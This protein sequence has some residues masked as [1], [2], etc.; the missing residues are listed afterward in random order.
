[1]SKTA[2][3]YS[4]LYN[5]YKKMAT[6]KTPFQISN[7][8]LT[9]TMGEMLEE[10]LSY[11]AL[12]Q[13][14]GDLDG[15]G[16]PTKAAFYLDPPF[17]EE[18]GY[19]KD[20]D[21]MLV[22]APVYKHMYCGKDVQWSWCLSDGDTLTYKVKDVNIGEG[23]IEMNGQSF[24]TFEDYFNIRIKSSNPSTES[25]KSI[26][27]SSSTEENDKK[28][29]IRFVGINCAET[30]HFE[31]KYMK[32][33]SLEKTISR[34]KFKDIKNNK[35]YK[36]WRYPTDNKF[37][38]DYNYQERKDDEILYFV[39][40][41]TSEGTGYHEI[42]RHKDASE[43]YMP[44]PNGDMSHE[45][46]PYE[47]VLSKFKLDAPEIDGWDA[48][49]NVALLILGKDET[50]KKNM[51][52]AYRAQLALKEQLEASNYKTRLVLDCKT[53]S[54]ASTF[55]SAG[56]AVFS[57]FYTSEF[58]KTVWDQMHKE[59]SDL[60][61]SGY[62]YGAY[63]ADVYGRYLG[64]IYSK[65][66]DGKWINLNKYVL[67]N[68]RY[69][70]PM[71]D[72]SGHPEL[73]NK[74]LS[75]A[76]QLWSY[77]INR[78]RWLD[79][80]EELTEE[81]YNHRIELHEKL[82]GLKFCDIRD[83]SLLIGDTLMLIPPT[84]IRSV[85]QTTYEK[86]PL[87]R[88]KGQITK[89]GNHNESIL[90]L[91]LYF[92]GDHGING[93][94]Y[95]M[96]LP[97]GEEVTYYMNGLRSLVSQFKLTP[98]L[99]IEN[100][101]INDVLNI[102]AVSL[103]NLHVTTVPDYPH[104]LQAV[105][106]LREFNYRLFMP[107][108]PLGIEA[109]ESLS[110]NALAETNP[111]FAKAFQWEVFRYY[112]QR[113]LLAGETI[114]K[115]D[116]NS[117]EY[118]TYLYRG[119]TALKP[120][121]LCNSNVSFYIPDIDWL[122]KVLVRIKDRDKAIIEKESIELTQNTRDF[123][124]SISDRIEEITPAA[125]NAKKAFEEHIVGSE[126]FDS[127]KVEK[128]STNHN[129]LPGYLNG[130]TRIY[131]KG[132][133]N[134]IITFYKPIHD[135]V[136]RQ[137]LKTGLFS[138]VQGE[139][140]VTSKKNEST[141]EKEWQTV[142]WSIKAKLGDL[143]KK[144]T[145]TE[146]S[147][148]KESIA[149]NLST[150]KEAILEDDSLVINI[151]FT[152]DKEGNVLEVSYDS[153]L[154]TETLENLRRIGNNELTQSDQNAIDD[155]EYNYRDP[156]KMPFVP[157]IEDII[158]DEMSIS[159]S[160]LFTETKLK[161]V[162]GISG[163][164]VGGQDSTINLKITTCDKLVVATLATLKDISFQF[165]NEY[166]RIMACTPIRIKSDF[167]QMYGINE[168]A[169]EMIDINTI[170]NMPGAYE[171]T[172]RLS[173]VDRTTRQRENLRKMDFNSNG[174]FV[175]T[176]AAGKQSIKSYFEIEDVL[177]QVELYPDLEIPTLEE[178]KLRGYAYIKYAL[179]NG[180]RVYPDPDF[181]M[182][183]ANSY[184]AAIMK[185]QIKDY[186]DNLLSEDADTEE[187]E[188]I[189]I[190]DTETSEKF[191]SKLDEVMGLSLIGQN[192]AADITDKQMNAIE[193][194]LKKTE[195][196]NNK[197]SNKSQKDAKDA[198]KALKFLMASKVTSGWQLKPTWT[199]P[200]CDPS[201]NELISQMPK[202]GT[203][204]SSDLSD[205]S[206]A[207][208]LKTTRRDIIKI[209]DKIL[210]EPINMKSVEVDIKTYNKES[211]EE[212]IIN[213][214]RSVV[215]DFFFNDTNGKALYELLNPLKGK[216]MV[217]GDTYESAE[218]TEWV[219][220]F[221]YAAACV[222]SS[223]KDFNKKFMQIDKINGEWGPRM[224]FNE[225]TATHNWNSDYKNIYVPLC[226]VGDSNVGIPDIEGATNKELE[227]HMLDDAINRG[228]VFGPF[229]IR[230]YT[231][232]ELVNMST[233]EL[234]I[235]YVSAEEYPLYKHTI[236]DGFLDPYY[237]K[238]N[239]DSEELTK[240][241]KG[242]MLN[243]KVAAQAFLRNCLV[244]MRKLILDGLFISDVDI[245]AVDLL[246]LFTNNKS[247][248]ENGKLPNIDTE[249][250]DEKKQIKKVIQAMTDNL[251][252]SMFIN[253]DEREI[254]DLYLIYASMCDL[255]PKSFCARMIYPIFL[256]ATDGSPLIYND[257][258]VRNYNSL[259]AAVNMSL[260]G[261]VDDILS[262]QVCTFFNAMAGQGMIDIQDTEKSWTD[263]SQKITNSV[264]KEVYL[265]FANNP[266]IYAMHSYYDMLMND[267]RG[268]LIRAFPTYYMILIDEGR[269]I[270]YWKLHDNFYNMS[271]ISDIQVVKSRKM[272]ADTA[273][274]TMTNAYNSYATEHDNYTKYKYADLYGV[275]DVF[276]SIF[277]PKR[278]YE[279]AEDIRNNTPVKDKVVLKPGIRMHIRMGY[280]AD[281]SRIPVIFNGRITEVNTG[282]VVDIVAQGDG[283]ELTN[284]LNTLGDIE[285]NQIDTAQSLFF[286]SVLTDF[287]GSF[288]KGGLSPK[289]LLASI[290]C[291][292][293]GGIEGIVNHVFNGKYFNTN[294]FG[295]T[296]FGDMRF[297]E[298]FSQ[299][300][301]AQNL[302]E[303]S[304]DDLLRDINSI[305]KG[306]S[307]K[308]DTPIINT[309]LYDK[310]FWDLMHMSARAGK[311]Y[312]AAVR[313]FGFRS[314]IFLGQNNHYY[315]Y[316]YKEVNGDV[317]EKR[318]PF[319]QYHYIEPYNDIIYNTIK[320]SE[321]DIKT[322]ATGIWQATNLTFGR[323]SSTV[324][325]F[326][327]D[328]NIYPEYQKSMTYDTGLLA[329][330]AGGI[331][332]NPIVKF[333]E[334]ILSGKMGQSDKTYDNKVNVKLAERMTI[335]ALKETVKDMY[336]GE[337]CI[338][339]SPAIK[340]FD[341]VHIFD[342]QEDMFGDFE[343]ETVIHSLNAYTGFTTTIHPDLIVRH[344]ENKQE[345]AARKIGDS[346]S[347]TLTATAM[348]QLYKHAFART[349][350]TLIKNVMKSSVVS[351]T[352]SA[353]MKTVTKTSLFTK[354][355]DK[356]DSKVTKAIVDALD[357]VLEDAGNHFN[358]VFMKSIQGLTDSLLD[359]G[360]N[361]ASSTKDLIK[362][363]KKLE[364]LN[365]EKFKENFDSM[366]ESAKNNG[367][368]DLVDELSDDMKEVIK[369]Y[370]NM[371]NDL[372]MSDFFKAVSNDKDL[373]K[374]INKIDKDLFEYFSKNGY[375]ITSREDLKKFNK[376]FQSDKVLETIA[377]EGESVIGSAFKKGMKGIINFSSE[378]AE[379]GGLKAMQGIFKKGT[380]V[381]SNLALK[382]KTSPALTN[383]VSAV[384]QLLITETIGLYS[385][386][387]F[388]TWFDSLQT[389]TIYPMKQYGKNFTA[390]INGAKACTYASPT[391]DGWNSVQG[392]VIQAYET[393][394]RMNPV[395][396][397]FAQGFLDSFIANPDTFKTIA[398][399]YKANLGLIEDDS[400]SE[401]DI[402]TNLYKTVSTNMDNYGTSKHAI[403]TRAR[404]QSFDRKNEKVS[405]S[406]NEYAI[407][408][409]KLDQ[410]ATNTKISELI[411]LDYFPGIQSYITHGKLKIGHNHSNDS[412]KTKIVVNGKNVDINMLPTK[413]AEEKM[414][415]N[416]PD[417]PMLQEDAAVI[418]KTI[419]D[420]TYLMDELA[421]NN[422]V[423]HSGTVAN[424]ND[425]R[426]TGFHFILEASNA[427]VT[428]AFDKAK[429]TLSTKYKVFEYTK[430]NGNFYTFKVYPPIY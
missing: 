102:E 260:S 390:G 300:E 76:F 401:D 123:A 30:P 377:A 385:R 278:Y 308:C 367:V 104:M 151:H 34:V 204:T 44:I 110:Q 344:K 83:N 146:I 15:S 332:V 219:K 165:A 191:I 152:A 391:A 62:A 171:V 193:E 58:I 420:E 371:M 107:D 372:D 212:K 144:L 353:L 93:I 269:K 194:A 70:I 363:M 321:S 361:E 275:K 177:S 59:L 213:S 331:E 135:T 103:L 365:M 246:K 327:L 155:E 81:S 314:T 156:V 284:P 291:A 5:K 425:W 297:T 195:E 63:G 383:I 335:N 381:L 310:T 208:K 426:S 343:V 237:N 199:A 273:S 75:D 24:K 84:N 409:I 261:N 28:F 54:M 50:E 201:T 242:I 402:V 203:D 330:G 158:T 47:T 414:D 138:K 287:R 79:S 82:S 214:I 52:D 14:S 142:I 53:L 26:T 189:E 272:A 170:E 188:K 132:V 39:Q 173:S 130:K 250:D 72:Y 77:D 264:S 161:G 410:L 375:K 231:V 429:K 282:E 23:P 143:S 106:T 228:H 55:T 209:I 270:G 111:I 69:T 202:A 320:A 288:A 12:L 251:F 6:T 397:F 9:P 174:G 154:F 140:R 240:Y 306:A 139:E 116:Y 305:S 235:K 42:I 180:K 27:R 416:T 150:E 245:L 379:K 286:P 35:A 97:S 198:E 411:A 396:K 362:C 119:I 252:E 303:V 352:S 29:M 64:A 108:L 32:K 211:Q 20:L 164:Y 74:E 227:K 56:T 413:K 349:N 46:K 3:Q 41:T 283:I 221:L 175:G 316:G 268:R 96:T 281:A 238:L 4:Q 226:N 11:E 347:G 60:N 163:Q 215:N 324:G 266:K 342:S 99:P 289:N 323:K 153:S 257:M 258:K 122:D 36:Y 101:Y 380:N 359:I 274:V 418:L 210:S 348:L 404:I 95:K 179:S 412:K 232:D 217:S 85:T 325:P 350:S 378:A 2:E 279:K 298:I 89:G 419:L 233:P 19:D 187:L 16:N 148:L 115:Y 40:M 276:D 370:D 216:Y 147:H 333:A 49:K 364:D 296:H 355:L 223:E 386:S 128:S 131:A 45:G 346:I 68:S 421:N 105:L 190:Y 80:F 277:S 168:V 329:D 121:S 244:W 399:T 38:F 301:T 388:Q 133:I 160:N 387:I 167:T 92:A 360:I 292:E 337:V 134:P 43:N 334:G 65:T 100:E 124:K 358:S 423:F 317:F 249:K 318:K 340:P 315:A 162:D 236:K 328:I 354:N 37:D 192:K 376:I 197:N 427:N 48:D 307:K 428:K 120:T 304:D 290:L 220:G 7:N 406:F 112:Y 356:F 126:F 319:Q 339:G 125:E 338:L 118:N 243:S 267:K 71:P 294:P 31:V 21:A 430:S 345:I 382:V 157:L 136:E 86:T 369:S 393:V 109:Q 22:E 285:A 247:I 184:T 149:L 224:W 398:N 417:L 255:L 207:Y 145:D 230:T 206:A 33:D 218:L 182:V 366:I 357:N 25:N 405:T 61:I 239:E 178:L 185:A 13:T 400:M 8:I 1:M 351:S 326:Y 66:K 18:L 341:R 254:S 407:R 225:I 293:Y 271:S 172:M 10:D 137:L 373:T 265:E 248:F 384:I 312:V 88:S 98:F 141:N 299:G 368:T 280:S 78:F 234:N 200:L 313:D 113:L 186:F 322:N 196:K 256:A 253:K 241:K 311:D 415:W 90:E 389:L 51:A 424:A 336:Q 183:Y 169:I 159:L 127:I 17:T 166:K 176:G 309:S 374:E 87:L 403:M 205:H 94:P 259:E 73:N 394:G 91:T 67:A 395:M 181:Y 57:L 129:T 408:N 222:C 114:D 117:P 392:M 262:R 295:I 229:A 302:Y 263:M 422:Y